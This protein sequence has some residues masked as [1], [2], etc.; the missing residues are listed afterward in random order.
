MGRLGLYATYVTAAL[1]LLV[2]ATDAAVVLRSPAPSG[3]LALLLSTGPLVALLLSTFASYVNYYGTWRILRRQD[4]YRASEDLKS[5]AADLPQALQG[6][7]A[8]RSGCMPLVS[9]LALVL[10]LVLAT[11]TIVPPSIPIAGAVSAYTQKF[12]DL[13]AAARATP[14]PRSGRPRRCAR[15]S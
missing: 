7:L 12:G 8:R 10:A 5:H 11:L 3:W 14:T 9:S 6:V 2:L 4:E 13:A 1:L 15:S